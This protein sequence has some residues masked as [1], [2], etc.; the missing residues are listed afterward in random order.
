MLRRPVAVGLVLG[1]GLA[2]LTAAGLAKI[3]GLD[4]QLVIAAYLSSLVLLGLLLLAAAFVP[5]SRALAVSPMECLA[6]E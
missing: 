3:Y 4:P 1:S 6:S 5:M 2:L